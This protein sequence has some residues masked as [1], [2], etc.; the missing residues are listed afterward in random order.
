MGLA[1]EFDHKEDRIHCSVKAAEHRLN[2]RSGDDG[3]AL[4]AAIENE[5]VPIGRIIDVMR[6]RGIELSETSLRR[7]RKGRCGACDV[8]KE[9]A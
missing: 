4:I 6:R 9:R 2:E 1:E 7:H 8:G 5:R 3:A